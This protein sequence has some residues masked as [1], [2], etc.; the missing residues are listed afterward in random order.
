MDYK[1]KLFGRVLRKESTSQGK[2][3]WDALRNRRFMNLKFRRQHVI[4]GFIVDFY[5][6]Q[7]KL[8]IK[9]DG[10]VHDRQ[11]DYDDL[12]QQLIENEGIRFIRI[13]NIDID[14]NVGLL[15]DKIQELMGR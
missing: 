12:R 15:T 2:K 3:V 11:K 14:K 7:L 8:A 9:I 13:T 1:K 10:A 5:C 4:E 6:H